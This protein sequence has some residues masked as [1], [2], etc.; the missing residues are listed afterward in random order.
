[1]MVKAAFN[2]MKVQGEMKD[3]TEVESRYDKTPPIVH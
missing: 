1:M 2:V 3:I